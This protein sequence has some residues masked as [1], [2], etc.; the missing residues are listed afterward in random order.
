MV[1]DAAVACTK[2]FRYPFVR[3]VLAY[4]TPSETGFGLDSRSTFHP[5]FFVEISDF[6]ERK[7]EVMA[8]Y[9]SELGVFPF[10]RSVEAVRALA[11]WR[12]ASSGFAAA[13][14]FQLLLE[15]H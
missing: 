15:R 8:V 1:F 4:E 14:A 6:L 9:G 11:T 12:G 5:D 2:W 13:E 7:L 3:R 10:P